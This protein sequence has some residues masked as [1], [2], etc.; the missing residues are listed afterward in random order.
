MFKGKHGEGSSI[1]VLSLTLKVA[2]LTDNE[3]QTCTTGVSL[4]S[5]SAHCWLSSCQYTV[6][7]P[8]IVEESFVPPE[9]RKQIYRQSEGE[10]VMP[11]TN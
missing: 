7:T 9:E 8:L 3:E 2:I 11:H 10:Q 5:V 4:I 6:N 1:L